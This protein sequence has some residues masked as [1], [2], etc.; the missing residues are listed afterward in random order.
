MAKA[1]GVGGVFIH[2]NGDVKELHSWYESNLGLEMSNY[3][4]GFI[5]GNQMM[6]ITFKRDSGQI[7]VINLRVDDI[8]TM[9]DNLSRKQVEIISQVK[10]YPYGKFAQFKDPFGNLIELW[11]AYENEYKEMVEREI[12]AYKKAN[13]I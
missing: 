7:P 1:I 13:S 5:T 11:E 6:L 3:G 2:L 12:I 10:E 8:E 4:S 9:I